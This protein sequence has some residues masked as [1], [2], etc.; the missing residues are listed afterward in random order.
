MFTYKVYISL[1]TPPCPINVF[2]KSVT[3]YASY[4]DQKT[5]HCCQFFCVNVENVNLRVVPGNAYKGVAILS[6]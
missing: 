1:L 3:R 6:L 2:F 5:T 4:L